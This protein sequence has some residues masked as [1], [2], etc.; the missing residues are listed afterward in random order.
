MECIQV[1]SNVVCLVINIS[2]HVVFVLDRNQGDTHH[3]YLIILP[4]R[5]GNGIEIRGTHT[6]YLTKFSPSFG[7]GVEIR[8][9][10][11]MIISQYCEL[12]LPN[13]AYSGSFQSSLFL[14]W[15]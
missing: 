5:F 1:S 4:L 9:T 12:Q 15:S 8:E 13:F 10:C 7:N 3:D 2:G 14:I 11:S 6:D